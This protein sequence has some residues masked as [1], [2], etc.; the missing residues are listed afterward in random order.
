MGIRNGKK[1]KAISFML[2]EEDYNLLKA[3]CDERSPQSFVIRKA[4]KLYLKKLSLTRD[5]ANTSKIKVVK[6]KVDNYDELREYAKAKKLGDVSVFATYS[7]YQ[8]MSKYPLKAKKE[9]RA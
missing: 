7:M 5:E 6:V 3:Y 1:Y 4:I 2:E 8:W 9:E